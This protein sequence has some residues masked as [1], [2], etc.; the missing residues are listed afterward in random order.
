MNTVLHL[1]AINNTFIEGDF[2]IGAILLP[3]GIIAAGAILIHLLVTVL[4]LFG[5]RVPSVLGALMCIAAVFVFIFNDFSIIDSA[6]ILFIPTMFSITVLLHSKCS[7]F[8]IF[9]KSIRY[10][11][12]ISLAVTAAF[13]ALTLILPFFVYILLGIMVLFNLAPWLKRY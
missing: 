4:G 7:E 5:S 2:R 10:T 8:V 13:I 12:L 6:Y 11:A 1:L 3:L 9:F